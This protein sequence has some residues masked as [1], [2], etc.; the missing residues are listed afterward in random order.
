VRPP[1]LTHLRALTDDTGVAQHAHMDVPNRAEGYC[2]DDVAR[3]F[4]VAIQASAHEATRQE[5]IDLGRAYLSFV[6][7]AQRADGRFR[8]FMAYDR[9]WLEDVGSEDS[10]GRAVWALGFGARY[11][12]I[13]RWR[14]LCSAAVV[15]ALPSIETFS[16]LRAR[17]Y[18]MLGLSSAASVEGAPPPFAETLAGLGRDLV[19]RYHA[20]RAPGWDWFEGTMTYDNARLSEAALRAGAALGDATLVETGLATLAFYESVVFEGE[21]FVPIGNRGWYRRGEVRARY[22]QQPLE[23]AAMVD[24]ELAAHAAT[25]DEARLA[26]AHEAFSWYLGKNDLETTLVR[27]G[28]CSDGIAPDSVNENMGAESTLAYLASAFALAEAE[29]A[30]V[31]K[32]T[33]DDRRNRR[34]ERRPA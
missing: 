18:A 3:A 26:R 1:P 4:M 5:G 15:R 28:G 21:R 31:A 23:A 33:R 16:W 25:G 24:A 29:E 9:R 14:T 7:H 19:A 11:A 20:A 34:P 8:N 12:P 2:T 17:A 30:R 13:E 10:C 32:Y 27:D 6:V 22:D